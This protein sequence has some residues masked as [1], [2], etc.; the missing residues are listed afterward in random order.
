MSN[1]LHSPLLLGVAAF[2]AGWVVAYLNRMLGGDFSRGGDAD[3]KPSRATSE[4]RIR[5]LDA[6]LRVSQQALKDIESE[7][8][9]VKAELATM[10]EESRGLRKT[11]QRRDAQLVEAKK[12]IN[13]E[14]MKTA[15][16]RKE[17]TGRA[18]E[19]IRANVQ[20][21]NFET[22]LGVI[23]A[24][25]DVV[26]EQFRRLEAEH[27]DLTDRLQHLKGDMTGAANEDPEEQENINDL[28]LDS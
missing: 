9:A 20:I 1:L 16:L 22:E 14:C 25:S 8:T 2:A 5:A 13:E 15:E 23:Q 17:L 18:E 27:E 3:G 10:N 6:D 12:N 21:K 7:H 24:G 19:T 26:A 4:H 28:I 11:L